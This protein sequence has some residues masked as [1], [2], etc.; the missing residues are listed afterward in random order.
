VT[1]P[2][3]VVIEFDSREALLAA[4]VLE[5]SGIT[6]LAPLARVLRTEAEAAGN[7][8]RLDDERLDTYIAAYERDHTCR[9]DGN[10]DG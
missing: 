3:S 2:D 6:A 1:W 9:F 8:G 4:M 10:D 5:E 7:Q